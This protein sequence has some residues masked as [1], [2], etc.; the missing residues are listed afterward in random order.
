MRQQAVEKLSHIAVVMAARTTQ[1]KQPVADDRK[2][3]IHNHG[4]LI[5]IGTNSSNV[6][7]A[8][9]KSTCLEVQTLVLN[10][11]TCHVPSRPEC[12]RNFRP[13]STDP[14]GSSNVAWLHTTLSRWNTRHEPQHLSGNIL[15]F[16]S[17]FFHS[18]SPPTVEGRSRLASWDT[19]ACCLALGATG[20]LL[21]HAKEHVMLTWVVKPQHIWENAPLSLCDSHT[22]S[23]FTFPGHCCGS[24]CTH[25]RPHAESFDLSHVLLGLF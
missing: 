11:P 9:T 16:F 6:H 7:T 17:L 22:H 15:S 3:R 10:T 12:R 21:G 13:P 8:V 1:R 19:V 4:F 20:L 23:C 5:A 24:S 18:V 2:Q 25:L 14:V